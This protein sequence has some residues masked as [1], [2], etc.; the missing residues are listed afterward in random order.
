MSEAVPRL[1]PSRYNSFVNLP[2]SGIILAFNGISTL[3][4]EFPIEVGGVIKQILSEPDADCTAEELAIKLT[5]IKGGFLIHKDTDEI[6]MLKVNNRESRFHSGSVGYTV[7]LTKDCNMRCPYCYQAHE[8]GAMS[9]EVADAFVE[10][11]SRETQGGK[12]FSI[13]WFGGEPLLCVDLLL[14]ISGRLS[15]VAEENKCSAGYSIITN[16]YLLT[17]KLAEEL[18]QY[19]CTYAQITLDGPKRVHDTKRVLPGGGP[20]YDRIVENIGTASERM[21]IDIRVNIDK[22]NADS[23]D[24]LLDELEAAG[25]R[26]KA[27]VYFARIGPVTEICADVAGICFG[28]EDFSKLDSRFNMKKIKRGWGAPLYPPSKG[29]FCSA[30]SLTGKTICPDGAIFK[31]WNEVSYPENAV[32]YLLDPKL[33]EAEMMNNRIKWLAWDPFEKAECVKCPVLPNCMGGCPWEGMRSDNTERGDCSLLKH[34]LGETIA[35]TYLH[36]RAIEEVK[37]KMGTPES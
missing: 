18:V 35:L 5:L 24:E 36:E 26:R 16:G 25:L 2:E 32:G 20:T 19:G 22:D 6:G 8:M 11:V 31:C 4:V 21:Q 14:D 3:A 12:P 15:K 27:R 30:D 7:L 33:T 28:V 34:N 23:V 13:T 37:R 29:G 1:K 10:L 17:D 9:G